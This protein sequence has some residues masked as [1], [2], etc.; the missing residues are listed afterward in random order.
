MTALP[1]DD[2]LLLHGADPTERI[3][4]LEVAGK[5]ALLFIR[6]PEDRII[7]RREPFVPWFLISDPNLLPEAAPGAYRIQK[8]TGSGLLK[9]LIEVDDWSRLWGLIGAAVAAYNEKHGCHCSSWRDICWLHV[10]TRPESQHLIRTGKSLFKGMQFEELHRF[11]IDLETV[12]RPGQN[13]PD[14]SHPESAIVIAAMSDNR[15]WS[16][17]IDLREITEPELLRQVIETIRRLNPDVIE[18]HN[19]L[20]FDLPYLAQRCARYGIKLALG[21]DGSAP[22]VEERAGRPVPRAFSADTFHIY[23]RHIVDTLPLVQRYDTGNEMESHSLKAA[24]IYFGMASK[25]RVYVDGAKIGDTWRSDPETLLAYALDDVHETEGLGRLL[26]RPYFYQTQMVPLSYQRLVASGVTARVESLFLREHLRLRVSVPTPEPPREYEG[27]FTHTYMRGVVRNVLYVDVHSLYPSIIAAY[28]I[29]PAKDDLH[30]IPRTVRLLLRQRLAAKHAA[31]QASDPD[32]KRRHAAISDAFKVLVNAIY[33]YL[34]FGPGLWNDPDQA[35]RITS[36]GRQIINQIINFVRDSGGQ[37]IEADTDGLYFVPP[38]QVVTSEQQEQYVK[39]LSAQLPPGIEAGLQGR[40]EAMLSHADKN[41]ALLHTDGKVTIRGSALRSQGLE[42][43][44]RRFLRE[45]ISHMLHGEFSRVADLYASMKKQIEHR[46]AP[47][48]WFVRSDRLR[49]SLEEYRLKVEGGIR[50][51]SAAYELARQC[52]GR[53]GRGDR[54]RYY[55]TGRSGRGGNFERPRLAEEYDPA[56]P[57]YSV[58]HYVRRLDEIQ[59]M[60]A[61]LFPADQQGLAMGDGQLS[62]F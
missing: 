3:V 17:V 62:L 22:Q 12:C 54:I 51:R 56:K 33:G 39:Q 50:A 57:D 60:L 21:R 16:H 38:P 53:Y 31:A 45:A 36:I 41:Y 8:L 44:L 2:F 40:Y 29:C 58:T 13:F 1:E 47:L 20:G 19:I 5:E 27:A 9:Y 52:E 10:V 7:V 59:A 23:G 35:D 18:G 25:D 43:Y 42:P 37:P 6:T 32:E 49:S 46:T 61:P 30:L 48:D 14:A 55:F 11:Q 28:D 26:T 4:A 34:G 15:G 24:A